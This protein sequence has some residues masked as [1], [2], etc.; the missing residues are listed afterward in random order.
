MGL[1]PGKTTAGDL[2]CVPLGCCVP[3][4]LRRAEG[5]DLPHYFVVGEAYVDG[6]MDGKAI[7]M[8]EKGE[9]ILQT[10]ELH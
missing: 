3:I 10:F 7:D 6:F 4:I 9:L 2:I 1:A 8:M 5:S